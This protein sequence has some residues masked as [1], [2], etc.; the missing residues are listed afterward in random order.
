MGTRGT[1]SPSTGSASGCSD[2]LFAGENTSDLEE[3]ATDLLP[4]GGRGAFMHGT[5]SADEGNG[6]GGGCVKQCRGGE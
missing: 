3:T 6:V 5:D 2:F 1:H 4:D